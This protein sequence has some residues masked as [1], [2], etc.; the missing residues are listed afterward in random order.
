MNSYKP[1]LF[2]RNAYLIFLATLALPAISNAE[3][4]SLNVV[5]AEVPGAEEIHAGNHYTAIEILESRAKDAD[6]HYVADELATLCALYIVTGKLSAA[7]VTCHHAVQTDRSDTAYNNRGVFRA[8]LGDAAGALEDFE[9]TRILPDDHQRYI[10]EL[11]KNDAR[12]IASRN[13]AVVSDY[14]EPAQKV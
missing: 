6:N 13:Y 7:S 4:Y 10:E 2:N 5:Y 14:I 9:R 11:K 3:T 1:S 8:R 12:R